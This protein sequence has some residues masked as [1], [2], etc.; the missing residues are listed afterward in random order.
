MALSTVIVHAHYIGADEEPLTGQVDFTPSAP[1]Q[2]PSTN[3][4]VPMKPIT[5]SLDSAGHVLDPQTGERGVELVATD[6]P[7]VQ[8]GDVTY[9][10]EPK[11]IGVR[12]PK[13]RIPV[14]YDS[15]NGEMQLADQA[16]VLDVPAFG[17][18]LVDHTHPVAPETVIVTPASGAAEELAP[19]AVHDLTL[20]A[21]CTISF[22]AVP[23]SDVGYSMTILLRQDGTGARVVTWPAEVTW[24]N[25]VEPVLSVAPGSVDIVSVLTIDGGAS[26]FGF[27]GPAG[28]VP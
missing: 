13:Y 8:P 1:I 3:Q 17:Y 11:I 20:T 28:Y 4:I 7:G 10:V 25:D 2:D 15:P 26:W 12:Y 9:W 19:A 16:P 5:C 14:P 24:P 27:V 22:A 23:G 18:A 6:F 21:D